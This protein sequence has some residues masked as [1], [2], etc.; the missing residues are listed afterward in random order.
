MTLFGGSGSRPAAGN[1]ARDL[2]E[3][4]RCRYFQVVPGVR[5]LGGVVLLAAAVAVAAVLN[6][7]VPTSAAFAVVVLVVAHLTLRSPA[8]M[9]V[10]AVV[11]AWLAASV[12]LGRLYPHG[13]LSAGLLLALLALPVA[14]GSLRSRGYAPWRTALISLVPAGVV[15]AGSAISVPRLSAGPAW[16]AALA[17][18]V[19]RW[20]Q[21]RR[22]GSA[23]AYE[24]GWVQ[25]QAGGRADS[26]G[27][28][29]DVSGGRP[30][31]SGGRPDGRPNGPGGRPDGKGSRTGKAPGKR[32]AS[33]EPPGDPA[34]ED[35]AVPPS[36]GVPAA[37]RAAYEERAAAEARPD[38][39]DTPSVGEA[40]AE[41]EAMIGLAPVKRQV[42]S[43]AA[44][45]EAAHLRAA[46]GVPTEKPMR[47]LVF[48]GPSGTGKTTVAR[49]LARIFHA[50]GLLPSATVVE[51]TRADLVGEYLG[52]TAIKT[53]ALVDAAL[54]GVLFVDEAYALANAAEGQPDRFGD[55]AVQTL[56]KRAEDDR[57]NLVV[58][59]AGYEDRMG[60]F[61]DSN[62]G[63]ASRFG[64]RVHFPSYSPDELLEIAEYHVG[65]RDDRFDDAARD[66]LATRFAEVHRRGIV[67]ELGN[68]RFVRSLTEAAAR[69]RDV[70]VVATVRDRAPAPETP[71]AG[72]PTGGATGGPGMPTGGPGMPT[73]DE[74]VTLTARDV[75][76]AFTELTERYRGYAETPTLEEA[77]GDLDAMIGLAPVK[78]QVHQ[79]AAQLQ[80]A[81][82]RQE[83]GLVTR[84]PTRHFVFTG[85]P[86][87]GKTTV[88]RVLGRIFAALGLLTRP[89]VVEVQRADLVGEHLGATALKTNRVVDSALGGV[90]FVDEAYSLVNPGYSGGDAFGSEAVQT[91][92]KRAEDDRD[93]L[94]VVL[95]GY[96]ADMDRFLASNP[97]LASRFDERVDFPSYGPDELLRIAQLIAGQGGDTWAETA[98]D[99]LAL[100][101]QRAVGLGRVDELGNGRFA[102]NLYEKASACRAL[103]AAAL[104]ESATPADLTTLTADDV[105]DA[106]AELTQRLSRMW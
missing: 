57:D 19:Y 35:D 83:Q 36:T 53:N 5:F 80:V 77:L 85:P 61:L 96:P 90:L 31:A 29:P 100:V 72:G 86:G 81:R 106:L 3:R 75:E 7:P 78:R 87:T 14:I 70:R 44:S 20:D 52:A 66:R 1:A 42:R 98:L 40:L 56:L 104:G 73:A 15:A 71:T 41:L 93:R 45:I 26:T 65:Q 43:I 62:P 79:I 12:A 97:G 101:F 24:T 88:A 68:G 6:L 38:E 99:D 13:Y 49:V 18:L 16:V 105:H 64:T 47:H 91:L 51:A 46:A 21:A 55:E 89:D 102:R 33:A 17:V 59:L 39:P 34:S 11:A 76:A 58:I 28:R 27:D 22:T 95:A 4:L 50:F 54:G 103:R 67:D 23:E 37:T 74:L 10:A 25:E 30:D 48:V 8:G 9:A 60:A 84:P 2:F 63:L 92:L 69:A 82:M 32:P 94:V